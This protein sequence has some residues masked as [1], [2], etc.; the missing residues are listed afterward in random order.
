MTSDS[1]SEP[2]VGEHDLIARQR[3]RAAQ[4]VA[5]AAVIVDDEQSHTL[6]VAA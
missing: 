5:Q 2:V 6:I 3:Q 1:A 4:H